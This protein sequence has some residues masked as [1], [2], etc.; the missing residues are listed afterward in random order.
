MTPAPQPAPGEPGALARLRAR[1]AL[2]ED[3]VDLA[4]VRLRLPELADPLAYIESRGDDDLPYWTKL[5]PAA[6]VLAGLAAQLPPAAEPILELGAGLGAPGL[7][8]A[9]KGRRVVL[10]DL[11][12]DALEF[13]RAAA[14]MNGL[15]DLVTVAALDWSDPDPGLGRF[16]TILGAEILYQPTIYPVLVE[17]LAKLLADDGT[18]F[19]SHEERPFAIGFFDLARERFMVRRTQ[20]RLRGPEGETTVYLYALTHRKD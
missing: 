9:A 7:A 18:A 11:D 12:A 20:R 15:S 1:F 13:A 16:R 8:A 2:T 4:G 10:S 14:E 5:W 6:L 17:V 19:V 3:R